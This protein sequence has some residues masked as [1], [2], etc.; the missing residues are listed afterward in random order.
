MAPSRRVALVHD[1]LLVTRGAER[2]FAAI[3]DVWPEA[4]IFTTVYSRS[5]SDSRLSGRR[6]ET[7]WLQRLRPSQRSFRRLLPLYPLAV[8]SLPVSDFDLVLS[9]SSAFA[10]GVRP[11]R[12]A[13][14][15]CYCHTP[16]RYAWHESVR[17]RTALPAPLR[18][19]ATVVLTRMRAW[20]RRA[21]DGVDHYIANSN[22]TAERIHDVYGRDASVI[23][24][25]VQVD[26]FSVGTPEDYVLFVGELVPHKRAEVALEAARLAGIPIRIVGE[27]PELP[28]LRARYGDTARFLGRVPDTELQSLYA[29]ALALVVPNAEE[30]GIAAVEAQAAGRPVV[31]LNAGGTRETVVDGRTGVLVDSATPHGFAAVIRELDATRFD[32]LAIRRNAER[33][34]VDRFQ[35]RLRSAVDRLSG[36]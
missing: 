32:P 27:G 24:P 34:S 36:E 33:F 8:R 2:T 7:S 16:F 23:H 4:P 25:P 14:H 5:G 20:D 26:R 1:Y 21:A 22:I 11:A 12:D 35:S 19:L 18:P 13:L 10:H 3:A 17:V 29:R 31:A 15:I 9:S 6:V 28:R 30:F